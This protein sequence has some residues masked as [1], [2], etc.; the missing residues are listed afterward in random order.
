MAPADVVGGDGG[1]GPDVDMDDGEL[2]TGA[3]ADGFIVGVSV[4]GLTIGTTSGGLRPPPPS[5]V[6][7][8]GI[9]VRPPEDTEPIAV[10]DEADAAGPAREL[11]AE[12]QPLDAIPVPPPS[13]SA[14]EPDMP[15]FELG[16]GLAIAQG[17]LPSPDNTPGAVGLRPGDASC[18]APRGTPVGATAV[19]G[20]IPSGDVMPSGD[21]PIGDVLTCAM[22]APELKTAAARVAATTRISIASSSFNTSGVSYAVQWS[23]RPRLGEPM[24]GLDDTRSELGRSFCETR[25]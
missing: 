20:P 18:I 12:V 4:G 5:W 14:A 24:R 9:P 23:A 10:G 13:K 3:G 15:V 25:R 16:L 7:P 17:A 11:P 22:A 19:P 21:V 8:S 2:R 6:A 1:V